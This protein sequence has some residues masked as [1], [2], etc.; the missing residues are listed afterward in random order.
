MVTNPGRDRHADTSPF[1][2]EIFVSKDINQYEYSQMV[3]HIIYSVYNYYT[4]KQKLLLTADCNHINWEQL[5]I[6]NIKSKHNQDYELQCEHLFHSCSRI[7]CCINWFFLLY[8]CRSTFFIL[9]F[10]SCCIFGCELVINILNWLMCEEEALLMLV[11][12]YHYDYE[13]H[14]ELHM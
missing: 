6:T 5:N 1:S 4:R 14:D 12:Q 13:I 3:F 10:P 9:C 2:L 8:I 11:N 7:L